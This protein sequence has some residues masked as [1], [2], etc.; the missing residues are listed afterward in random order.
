MSSIF[1]AQQD[2]RFEVKGDV[3]EITGKQLHISACQFAEVPIQD[4]YE[5]V[6]WHRLE[7]VFRTQSWRQT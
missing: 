6:Q 1:K 4:I 3:V 2:T 5:F 7:C